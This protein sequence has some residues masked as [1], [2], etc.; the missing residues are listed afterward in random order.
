LPLLLEL[1][2]SIYPGG[3]MSRKKGFLELKNIKNSALDG[4][5]ALY[6]VGE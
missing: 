3:E 2:S 4:L 1:Y 5:Y 6:N